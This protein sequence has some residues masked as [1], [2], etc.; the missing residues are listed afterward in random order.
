MPV[1]TVILPTHDH[2]PTLRHPIRS[3]QEQTIDDLEIFVIGRRRFRHHARAHRR[4]CARRLENPVLRDPKGPRNGDIDR[5]AALQEARGEIVCYEA[6][7]DLWGPAQVE[8]LR[9]L[10]AEADF[11]YTVALDIVPMPPCFLRLAV[12][13]SGVFRAHMHRGTTFCRSASS[14]IRPRSIG[15]FLTGGGR[16]RGRRRRTGRVAAVLE[17]P[18]IRGSGSLGRAW[19]ASQ[20]LPAAT[21]RRRS[22][23]P[24]LYGGRHSSPVGAGARSFYRPSGGALS[25]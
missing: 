25:R 9:G 17:L 2:G 19:S 15:L 21:G 24:S 18:G 14:V 16:R 6:D 4:A 20:I 22:G 11:V 7:D 3:V 23:S 8:E 13:G 12:V 10:L 1:V 5:H